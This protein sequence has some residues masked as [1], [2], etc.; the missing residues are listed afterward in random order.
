MSSPVDG[1]VSGLSTSSL[2][3]QLMQAESAGQTRLKDRVT[4]DQGETS[5]LQS[6]NS[7]VAALKSAAQSVNNVDTWRLS[8]ATSSS[9][10][11]AV[12]AAAGAISGQLTI[13]VTALAKNHVVTMDLAD[14]TSPVTTG[15]GVYITVNNVVTHIVVS[16][17]TA[18][19]LVSAINSAGMSVRAAVVNADGGRIVLQL[20][21]TRTGAVN[22]FTMSGLVAGPGAVITQGSDAQL[23]VGDP[24]AGGYTVSSPTNTFANV[25]PNVTFTATREQL[26]ITIGVTAD[27]DGTA[28]RIQS[29]VD[30]ANGLLAENDKQ[31]VL[32]G[33]GRTAGPLSGDAMV[34]ALSS[35]VLSSIAGGVTNYGSLAQ[36]GIELT[37]TG[38]L[39]FNA[40]KFKSAM[41]ANPAKVQTAL[42]DTDGLANSLIKVTDAAKSNIDSAMKTRTTDV[43]GLTGQISEWDER[44]KVRQSSLQRQFTAMEVALGKMKDQSSWLAGQIAKL[45]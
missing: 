11:L 16:P 20:T 29:L 44:L 9:D 18:S 24:N 43:R 22:A 6:I 14:T 40:D 27:L 33:E 42:T 1:L 21:S 8:K 19:G 31:A 38:R 5:A 28:G 7:K 12:T 26:G 32:G 23:T 45:G 34:R 4:K 35:K 3:K 10:A 17:D 39:T 25:L 37:R 41:Q 2:I 15:N 30:A 36:L 13:G